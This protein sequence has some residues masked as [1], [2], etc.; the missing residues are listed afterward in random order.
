[1]RDDP[2]SIYMKEIARIP[3]LTPEEEKELLKKAKAGD[4]KAMEKFLSAHL[5]FVI[6]LAKL[7]K[8][9]GIPFSELINEGNWG[10]VRAFQSFDPNKGVRFISYAAWWIRQRMLK[11][12]CSQMKVVR[13]PTHKMI[14]SKAVREHEEKIMAEKGK[15]PGVKE[16]AKALGL[17]EKEVLYA[18]ELAQ[19][20]I[21]LDTSIRE[22]LQMLE[23]IEEHT[24][25]L[26][27]AALKEM[28]SKE[29]QEKIKELSDKERFVLEK[30]FGLG[31]NRPHTLKEIGEMLGLTRERV[32]QIKNRAIEKLR[33]MSKWL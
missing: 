9:E 27:D 11:L 12:I 2:L 8:R 3:D 26:E 1:M 19:K 33:K 14:S 30:Y 20:D 16:I 29:I 25:P 7:Y 32:R 28:V 15:Q 17:R 31:D 24:E 13:Y 22:G 21:S 5:K 6:N 23:V 4:K 10:L 18:M